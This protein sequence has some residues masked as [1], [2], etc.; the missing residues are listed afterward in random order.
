MAAPST[1]YVIKKNGIAIS[2]ANQAIPAPVPTLHN[3]IPLLFATAL[4]A[5]THQLEFNAGDKITIEVDFNPAYNIPLNT[6][7]IVADGGNCAGISIKRIG[8][9]LPV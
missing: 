9:K 1:R 4:I 2:G 8:D 6:L 7:D 5:G 3:D